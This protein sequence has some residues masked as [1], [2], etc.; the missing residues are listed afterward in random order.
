MKTTYIISTQDSCIV[1]DVSNDWST[2]KFQQWTIVGLDHFWSDFILTPVEEEKQLEC[3]K[4]ELQNPQRSNTEQ[5]TN[6][7]ELFPSFFPVPSRLLSEAHDKHGEH[8]Q[9]ACHWGKTNLDGNKSRTLW[10]VRLLGLWN[11][12]IKGI[13]VKQ[14]GNG[15][16]PHKLPVQTGFFEIFKASTKNSKEKNSQHWNKIMLD[17]T[18]RTIVSST[19]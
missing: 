5:P 12:E 4:Q 2:S 1:C 17:E 3:N 10:S 6:C 14:L 13:Q 11:A 16:P 8:S 15:I 19:S 18:G 9:D 7:T